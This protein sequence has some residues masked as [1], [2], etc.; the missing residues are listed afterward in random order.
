MTAGEAQAQMHPTRADPQTFL[1]TLGARRYIANHFQMRVS[2]VLSSSN[3]RSIVES[4]IRSIQSIRSTILPSMCPAAK[5]SCAFAASGGTPRR[6]ESRAS[7]LRRRG[8]AARSRDL[9]PRGVG[10]TFVLTPPLIVE[11]HGSAR[12]SKKPRGRSRPSLEAGRGRGHHHG[13]QELAVRVMLCG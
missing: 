7:P 5:P 12:S 1:A 2:H 8:P 4:A 6:S 11:R 13:R 3:R 9:L 10:D